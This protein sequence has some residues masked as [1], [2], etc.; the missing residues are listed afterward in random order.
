MVLCIGPFKLYFGGIKKFNWFGKTVCDWR[1]EDA[2]FH[3][4]EYMNKL[5]AL[6]GHFGVIS[7]LM[8]SGKRRH[9]ENKKCTS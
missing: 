2:I 7:G 8:R 4:C 1:R 9:P 5:C 3:I 6:M